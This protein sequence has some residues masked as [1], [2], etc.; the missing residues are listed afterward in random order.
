MKNNK[1]T[2]FSHME[3]STI[4]TQQY[5]DFAHKLRGETLV[6][7]FGIIKNVFK[8]KSSTTKFKK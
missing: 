2:A 5:V 1:S 7:H 6:E 3:F 8:K 4:N